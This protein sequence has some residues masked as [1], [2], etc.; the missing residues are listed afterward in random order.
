[1]MTAVTQLEPNSVAEALSW[2]DSDNWKQAI[3]DE[4]ACLQH[5]ATW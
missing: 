2:E 4:L 1:M 3:D 5:Y